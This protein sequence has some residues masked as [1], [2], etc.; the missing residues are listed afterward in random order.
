MS[1]SNPK[2]GGTTVEEQRA[3]AND[4][5]AEEVRELNRV[6][7]ALAHHIF[8][9]SR[10]VQM[11]TLD[12]RAS[13]NALSQV[14]QGIQQLCELDGRATLRVSTDLLVVNDLRVVVDTQSMGPIV[15]VVDGMKRCRVEEIEFE[16]DID[17]NQLGT[18]L[19]IF[20]G[21]V[22]GEDVFG[23]LKRAV[24]EAGVDKVRVVE[25][26]DRPKRL[27]DS[28]IGKKEV[29]EE[30][31]K[32]YERTVLFTG[33]V[34][35][36]AEQHRAI[37]VP[38]ALRLTQQ[39]VDIIQVDESILL[40]LA[41]IK[42]YDE[43]TF[44]HS[45]N[46]AVLSMFIGD[47]IGLS[48]NDVAQV[49]LAALLHDIGKTHVPLEVLNKV[50]FLTNEEWAVMQSHTMFGALELSRAKALRTAAD[51]I[52]VALQHHVRIGGGGYPSKPKG[53]ALHPYTRIVTVADYF[54][55]MTTPR[56]Y[57]K[58][59]M[60]PD[61]ALRFVLDNSGIV[62]DPFIAKTFIQAMGLY[63][64]GTVV[65]LDTGERAVVVRQNPEPRFMHRPVASIISGGEEVDLAEELADG[66]Y[67]RSIVRAVFDPD[68]E[69]QKANRFI[70]T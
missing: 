10:T 9:A 30:S 60:T 32:L 8:S 14:I 68:A 25:W 1:D 21:E 29:R 59:P 62:F 42:S 20:F 52:F 11:H 47:R 46:V 40:G 39:I 2:S 56:V 61:R 23:S 69:V 4:H 16:R 22:G 49:G 6:A 17:A 7:A 27:R 66:A 53:W 18:F 48:K 51:S 50:E 5:A 45:A 58:E 13:Q 44:A 37:P 26:I 64:V 43:Y 15:Y 3:A 38:K 65:D 67:R 19:R 41:S 28:V 36:A 54:D 33:E 31:N 12:N 70:A 35:R 55:A 24:S 34:L 57:K 63:P